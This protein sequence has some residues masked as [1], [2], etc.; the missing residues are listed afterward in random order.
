MAVTPL[1]ALNNQHTVFKNIR[2]LITKSERNY[3]Q[4]K[5]SSAFRKFGILE[6]LPLVTKNKS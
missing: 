3:D 4:R 1:S 5:S 6:L 2:T